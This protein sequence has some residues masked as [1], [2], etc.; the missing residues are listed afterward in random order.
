[1]KVKGKDTSP[2]AIITD[3]SSMD[4][5]LSRID[6][7]ELVQMYKQQFKQNMI[8]CGFKP[9]DI[10]SVAVLDKLKEQGI[11]KYEYGRENFLKACWD[12]T[13]EYSENIRNLKWM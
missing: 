12:W 1:M 7:K 10:V 11:N 5:M 2:K 13:H 4:S 6:N 8:D 9:G 3:V